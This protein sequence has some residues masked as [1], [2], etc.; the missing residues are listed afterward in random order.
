MLTH[1]WCSAQVVL[2]KLS[3]TRYHIRNLVLCLGCGTTL[4]RL[5]G[6]LKGTIAR[7]LSASDCGPF[8]NS[9]NHRKLSNLNVVQATSLHKG[10]STAEPNLGPCPGILHWQVL[11][12]WLADPNMLITQP[13][14]APVYVR[15][16]LS[17]FKPSKSTTA[18]R[19]CKKYDES[20]W[21]CVAPRS[22]STTAAKR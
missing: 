8:S 13:H 18:T 9:G 6:I 1:D 7:L 14:I 4:A 19:S 22:S 15:A 3:D 10:N 16:C 17:S 21:R 2:N 20:R 5:V 11:Y 12:L